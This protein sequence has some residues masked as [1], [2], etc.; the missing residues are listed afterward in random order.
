MIS[1]MFFIQWLEVLKIEP[2]TWVSTFNMLANQLVQ[3]GMFDAAT[4][5]EDDC[6]MD[7]AA[8]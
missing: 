2:Y 7:V 6:V 3:V 8:V 1:W 4:N 5:V